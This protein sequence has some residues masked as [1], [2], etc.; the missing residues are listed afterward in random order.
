MEFD[1]AKTM[2][3]IGAILVVLTIVPHAGAIL[4][5]LGFILILL[6]LNFFS[7]YYGKAE[8]FK[9][10]LIAVIVVAVGLIAA[11]ITT[12]D[13]PWFIRVDAAT[14]KAPFP[15][16]IGFA[17]CLISAIYFRRSLIMLSEVSGVKMF[18]TA[19]LLYL[20]GAIL[21]IVPVPVGG[22][23]MIIA[24]VPLTVAFFAMKPKLTPA[25]ATMT[26]T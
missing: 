11:F 18:S 19:A 26:P 16:V 23:I 9:N 5:L 14:P 24:F 7:E 8:I 6:S 17:I 12:L 20:I 15:L 2:G 4:G 25:P 10:A 21:T 13:I 1:S 22:I 3:T